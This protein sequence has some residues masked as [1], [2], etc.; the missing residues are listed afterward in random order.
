MKKRAVIAL[1][2]TAG[3]TPFA[4]STESAPGAATPSPI[5]QTGVIAG[6]ALLSYWDFGPECP[7]GTGWTEVGHCQPYWDFD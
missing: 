1:L 2:F 6:D 4:H 5:V 3:L 7:E